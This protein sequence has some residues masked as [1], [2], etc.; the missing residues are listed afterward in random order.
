[1]LKHVCE[2]KKIQIMLIEDN[3]LLRDSI[4][5]IIN[6]H[7]DMH[8]IAA[9]GNEGRVS[10]IVKKHKPEIVLFELALL[11]QDNL[12]IVRQ[13][14]ETFQDTKIIIMDLIPT[15]SDILAFV[16]A[17]VSGFILKD[18]SAS[19]MS[20]IIRQVN[21][22]AQILPHQLTGSLFDQ[23]VESSTAC[24]KITIIDRSI[25]LTKR[26]KQVIL[27]ISDGLT[28]KEI[29]Q[30]LRLSPSTVKSHV[31]N[32][33]EKLALTTRIQIAKYAHTSESN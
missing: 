14:K 30:R 7:A 33:L 18:A 32:I 28:N 25:R 22:G 17:G 19:E 26:E 2:M 4:T 3:R 11:N 9:I 6:K 10:E 8:V 21:D 29:A 16:Q 23:I 5:A 31:H 27:L 20:N 1:M 12:Q 24:T 13:I 15:Q